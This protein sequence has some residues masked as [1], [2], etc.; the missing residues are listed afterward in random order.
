[1][2]DPATIVISPRSVFSERTA[3]VAVGERD[4][5]ETAEFAMNA[6]GAP[7]T[8]A[9]GENSGSDPSVTPTQYDF[10]ALKER[11][12]VLPRTTSKTP[13]DVE[14]ICVSLQTAEAA[15]LSS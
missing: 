11:G 4:S 2:F 7:V 9:R 10:A 3:P 14:T 5:A 1:M 13:R 8:R 15:V 12:V 6:K